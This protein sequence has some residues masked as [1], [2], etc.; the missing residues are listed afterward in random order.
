MLHRHATLSL[1]A[2]TIACAPPAADTVDAAI[3]RDAFAPDATMSMVDASHP[4]DAAPDLDADNRGTA[5]DPTPMPLISRDVPAFASSGTPGPAH[6]DQPTSCW[7]PS[8]MPA[9]IAY[10][11]SSAHAAD[12][13]FVGWYAIHAPGWLSDAADAG[14]QIPTDYTIEIHTGP[15]AAAPPTTGWTEIA[16][17]TGNT[18]GSRGLLASAAGA[19]WIRMSVTASSGGSNPCIDLD[20]HSAPSGASDSWLYMGDSVTHIT[21]P[22]AFSDY[23]ARTSMAQSGRWP[24]VFEAAIGGTNTETALAVIDDTLADFRGR[25]VVLAYGTNDHAASF[26]MNELIDHVIASGRV[27]VVPHIP[28]SSG[29]PEGV[30]I[31]AQ[32]D[33]IYAARPEVLRGPDLWAAF[34]GRTDLI[35]V[36]DIHPNDL[37][38]DHLRQTWAD[39]LV[40]LPHP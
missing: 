33:A 6:D 21:F 17:V 29:S 2:L 40:A 32:I 26:H 31:N 14:Q 3:V 38:R 25:Y 30:Q 18:H 16:R 1:L 36:G 35:P 13:L 15:S 37:G 23:R 5:S 24:A 34:D 7:S 10:D 19:N 39:W 9:W 27:P 28:W 4:V 20:V 8:S 12:Q 11:L 22:Y